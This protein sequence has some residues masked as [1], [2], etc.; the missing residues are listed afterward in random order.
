MGGHVYLHVGTQ[1]SC[2]AVDGPCCDPVRLARDWRRCDH[3][4]HPETVRELRAAVVHAARVAGEG[5]DGDGGCTFDCVIYFADILKE[6]PV[7]ATA[8]SWI[9]CS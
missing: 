2:R 9:E 6:V 4:A 5:G 7:D 3:I 8:D 1:Q